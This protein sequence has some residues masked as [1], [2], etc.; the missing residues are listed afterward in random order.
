MITSALHIA[1]II[2]IIYRSQLR[3]NTSIST[4][5]PLIFQFGNGIAVSLETLP[6]VREDTWL[7]RYFPNMLSATFCL[8]VGIE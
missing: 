6:V 4:F 8:S 7:C 3:V 1:D 5:S 2:E